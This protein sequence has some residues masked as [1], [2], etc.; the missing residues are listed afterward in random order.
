MSI[1]SRLTGASAI[2]AALLAGMPALAHEGASGIIKERMDAMGIMAKAM[3][4]ASRRIEANRNLAAIKA[5]AEKISAI[6]PKIPGCFPPG[7]TQPP[8]DAKAEIWQRWDEFQTLAQR[9][10]TESEALA[11]AAANGDPKAIGEQFR[12][13]GRAC[14]ACHEPFRAKR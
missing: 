3:K 6:A 2:A 1:L 9:L 14:T 8:T 7:S 12:V 10:R 13:L 4:D 5:D 11:A